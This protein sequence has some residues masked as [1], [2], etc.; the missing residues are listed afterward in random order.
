METSRTYLPAAGR[1]WLLPLYDPFVK[2]LGGD[3]ARRALLTQAAVQPGHRILDV[4]CG[5]GTLAT[6]VLDARRH[7]QRSP[8][9]S[10]RDLQTSF[11]IPRRRLT[12]SSLRSCSTTSRRTL[13][14]RCCMRSG[15]S[16][17]LAVNFTYSISRDGRTALP[18][19][20]PTY[21]T[22]VTAWKTI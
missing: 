21:F 13:R 9:G 22:Q 17:D 18:A 16:L 7:A 4:A 14:E 20:W 12:A 6:P 1:D 2:L 8:S 11:R 5:T 15:L 3:A 10:T 19:S